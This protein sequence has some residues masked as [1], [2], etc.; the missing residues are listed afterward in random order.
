MS[1]G[2]PIF[3]K[4]TGREGQRN[5]HK[6]VRLEADQMAQRTRILTAQFSP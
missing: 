6:E 5:T 4:S 2:I 3:A 1:P